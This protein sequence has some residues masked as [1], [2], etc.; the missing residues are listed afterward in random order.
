VAT[1]LGIYLVAAHVRC[2]AAGATASRLWE[3]LTG[4]VA[5]GE[6]VHGVVLPT[7]VDVDRPEDV[8]LA[9]ALAS[10][11]VRR[12]DDPASGSLG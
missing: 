2:L 10:A 12:G 9:G 7:V 3:F 1:G 5:S 11:A 8:G 6:P 4:L